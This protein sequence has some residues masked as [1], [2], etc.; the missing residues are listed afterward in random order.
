MV[1]EKSVY[2]NIQSH[3][4]YINGKVLD[5]FGS[6]SWSDDLETIANEI[7]FKSLTKLD[8]GAKFL[9]TDNNKKELFRG[10][11]TDIEE[12]KDKIFTYSGFDYG[13]YLNKNQVIIQFKN[14][15]TDTAIKQLCAKVNIPVGNICSISPQVQKIYKGNAV[16]DI[17]KELLD[18]ASKKTGQ[19]Y[20]MQ[21]LNGT[22]TI[23]NTLGKIDP[24]I[25]L[26]ENVIIKVCDTAGNIT[27][28]RSIQ[29]LKNS[30]LLV[31]TKEKQTF[32]TAS[33]KDSNNISK[34]GLLQQIET[35][36]KDDKTSRQTIVNNLLNDLNKVKETIQIEFLGTNDIRKGVYLALDY[37][38]Y[39]LKGDYY[40]KNSS[41]TIE[42]GMHRVNA[43]V[44]KL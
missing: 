2:N 38:E 39:G 32:V 40:I 43:E 11:I 31:D 35:V 9:L 14:V 26:A 15:R 4:L 27:Y 21:C 24:V 8:D 28:K 33:A 20:I 42:N 29:E 5:D 18:T 30:V 44:I 25:K 22:L 1:T 16:S 12:D 6:L 23:N 13:F 3:R 19:K 36:D 41:H 37:P 17:I 34:F 10:I 7:S